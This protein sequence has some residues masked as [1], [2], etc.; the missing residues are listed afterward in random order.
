MIALVPFKTIPTGSFPGK[1]GE[2]L[3]AF[4]TGHAESQFLSPF[5]QVSSL[6]CHSRSQVL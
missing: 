4:F 1:A 3:I 5:R 2:K 6:A